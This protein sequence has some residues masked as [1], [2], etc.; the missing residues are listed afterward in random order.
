MIYFNS[1]DKFMSKL[2]DTLNPAPGYATI[3]PLT[4]D[5]SNEAISIAKTTIDSYHKGRVVKVGFNLINEHGIVIEP[6]FAE[7]DIVLYSF[8]GYEQIQQEGEILRIIKFN[9]VIG[10]YEK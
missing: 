6:H 7:G 3:E 10:V 4:I 5:K 9:Q 1:H 2:H 8:S